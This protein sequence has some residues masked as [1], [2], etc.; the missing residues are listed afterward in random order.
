MSNKNSVSILQIVLKRPVSI[1]AIVIIFHTV[2]LHLHKT[3]DENVASEQH[4]LHFYS[5][6]FIS[7]CTI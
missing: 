6:R 1:T 4:F 2:R 7:Y 5:V 3:M